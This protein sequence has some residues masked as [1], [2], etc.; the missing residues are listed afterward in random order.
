MTLAS[1]P[2]EIVQ[3]IEREIASGRYRSEDELVL[4][5]VKVLRELK[6][7]HR[8]LCNDIQQGMRELDDGRGIELAGD[9]ELRQFLNEIKAEGRKRSPGNNS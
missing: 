4:D 7:R 6:E 3:F 5:A 2:S 1:M 8:G 9:A